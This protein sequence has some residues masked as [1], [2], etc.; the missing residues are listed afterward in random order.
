MNTVRFWHNCD[1]FSLP[2]A[3][4]V[5]LK[6]QVWLEGELSTSLNANQEFGEGWRC[7]IEIGFLMLKSSVRLEGQ[8]SG[9]KLCFTQ[10]HTA[11]NPDRV[12]MHQRRL[13]R[14]NLGFKRVLVKPP[15]ELLVWAHH[16]FFFL[17]DFYENHHQKPL[18]IMHSICHICA[19]YGWN[20]WHKLVIWL[21]V[22]YFFIPCKAASVK[23]LL[24][25]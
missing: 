20:A 12:T 22:S 21:M 6:E 19:K 8:K 5:S 24:L 2:P 25:K 13:L 3:S 10:C 7:R 9:V 17:D 14:L 11:L 4:K 16:T 18:P 23:L 1:K 15:G